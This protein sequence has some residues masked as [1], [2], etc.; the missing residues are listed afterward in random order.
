MKNDIALIEAGNPVNNP[1]SHEQWLSTAP[2]DASPEELTLLDK[3]YQQYAMLNQL[4]PIYSDINTKSAGQG[5]AAVQS[6][7]PDG[8]EDDFAFRQQR[9][10]Q[11]VQ[12]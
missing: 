10:Q 12:K 9:Y 7:R 8:S 3:Q 5:L 11:A 6:I 1:I 2:H 4:Q